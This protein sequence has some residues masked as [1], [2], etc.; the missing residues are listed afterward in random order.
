[1][2]VGDGGGACDGTNE[3]MYLDQ[4]LS[5]VRSRNRQRTRINAVG[6]LDTGRIRDD[7]LRSLSSQT[8]GS[9]VKITR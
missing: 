7:F 2:Y 3:Q 9:Y 1:M 5:M 8:G 4:T 6:V